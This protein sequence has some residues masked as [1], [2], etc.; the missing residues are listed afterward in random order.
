MRPRKAR[1]SIWFWS[2][3][4]GIMLSGVPCFGASDGDIPAGLHR[5][6][7]KALLMSGTVQQRDM[8]DVPGHEPVLALMRGCDPRYQ[9]LAV[10]ALGE[11]KCQE[12][13]D[14]LIVLLK[15]DNMHLRHNAAR[16][17]GKIGEAKAVM[18]L[19]EVLCCP[20]EAVVVQSAAAVALGRLGD[21]RA[22]RMLTHLT[23]AE[24]GRLKQKAV[25]ALTQLNRHDEQ[26]VAMK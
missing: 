14:D 6:L 26:E 1:P 25:A 13:A 22:R 21:P 18:P 2:I 15:S 16:A 12:A 17:L 7:V 8:G 4:L 5:C 9:G 24:K 23:L 20:N 19:I 3:V 10:Y 11:M